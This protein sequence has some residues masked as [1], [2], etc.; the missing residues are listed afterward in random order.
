MKSAVHAGDASMTT[1]ADLL[2]MMRQLMNQTTAAHQS[3][4]YKMDHIGGR[5]L[6]NATSVAK[7]ESAI[8]QRDK[9]IYDRFAKQDIDFPERLDKQDGGAQRQARGDRVGTSR[10]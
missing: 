7:L 9:A 2:V 10:V 4:D 3:T 1:I 5:L 6:R 8:E